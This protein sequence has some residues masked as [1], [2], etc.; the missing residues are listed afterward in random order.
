MSKRKPLIDA[1]GEVRELTSADLAEFKPAH[2]VL[3]LEVHEM[4]GIRRRGPQKAPTKVATTIRLSPE[5]VEF[6]R[7]LGSGWQ[8]RVDGVLRDYVA[9][10]TPR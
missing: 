1:G 8:S 10:H 6:F 7:G 9:K 5:V 2:E 4:L 3:P